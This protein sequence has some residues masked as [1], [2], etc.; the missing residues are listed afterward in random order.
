MYCTADP[1]N[2][3]ETSQ[4]GAP[5]HLLPMLSSQD[6]VSSGVRDRARPSACATEHDSA[7]CSPRYAGRRVRASV[8]DGRPGCAFGG[9][10]DS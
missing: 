2:D 1:L 10:R 7:G 4:P 6:L 8:D 5:R 9:E 3:S